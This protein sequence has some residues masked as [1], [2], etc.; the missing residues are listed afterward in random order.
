MP[1]GHFLDKKHINTVTHHLP[2]SRSVVEVYISKRWCLCSMRLN[3]LF[4]LVYEMSDSPGRRSDPSP[5]LWATATAVRRSSCPAGSAH[6][7]R[8][9]WCGYA[10]VS[11]YASEFWWFHVD[12]ML[13][14]DLVAHLLDVF[15]V[16]VQRDKL[17]GHDGLSDTVLLSPL[18]LPKQRHSKTRKQRNIT[19]LKYNKIMPLQRI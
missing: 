8:D 3:S 16:G 1:Y 14:S 10:S 7:S 9:G 11:N 19:E 15:R 17:I 2:Y 12:V 13:C 18:K 4:S 6:G 5:H